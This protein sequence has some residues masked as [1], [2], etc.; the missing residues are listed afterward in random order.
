MNETKVEILKCLSD[1]QCGFKAYRKEIISEVI[2]EPLGRFSCDIEIL[3]RAKLLNLD[4][5]EVPVV[6]NHKK[7][8][9][10]SNWNLF[11]MYWDFFRDFFWINIH[12]LRTG[13]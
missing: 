11:G 10:V 13:T 9:K 1:N 8:S 6:W 3:Y 7:G 2:R 12:H 4:I 5:G